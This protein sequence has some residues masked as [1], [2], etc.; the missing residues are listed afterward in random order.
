MHSRIQHVAKRFHDH[1]TNAA[2]AFGQRVGA[3][4]HHCARLRLGQRRAYTGRVRAHEIYLKLAHLLA[5]NAHGGEL[6][7]S[8]VDSVGH[9]A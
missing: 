1:R 8:R 3:Q 6:A 4:Q 5:G 7:K 9:S 2:Q